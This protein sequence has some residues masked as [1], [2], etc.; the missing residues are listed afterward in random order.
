M[1][2]GRHRRKRPA[3]AV[4]LHAWRR[5]YRPGAAL[6]YMPFDAHGVYHFIKYH[7]NACDARKPTGSRYSLPGMVRGG[8]GGACMHSSLASCR[9]VFA[10]AF[11]AA[12]PVVVY[13]LLIGPQPGRILTSPTPSPVPDLHMYMCMHAA[14]K[15]GADTTPP[16]GCYRM[17]R[18]CVSMFPVTPPTT[19]LVTTTTTTTAGAG[20][21]VLSHSPCRPMCQ[22]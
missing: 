10:S 1:R 11:T 12:R 8:W 9:L 19:R 15:W 20:T 18:A 14:T 7:V 2:Q 4:R 16:S 6:H 13:S 21:R 22:M 5:G 17:R 3:Y